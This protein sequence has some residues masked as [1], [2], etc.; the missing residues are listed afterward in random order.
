MKAIY[1]TLLFIGSIILLLSTFSFL[2]PWEA[3]TIETLHQVAKW[4]FY[5]FILEFV[6]GLIRAQEKWEYVKKEW[7]STLAIVASISVESLSGFLGAV[8]LM[9]VASLLKSLKGIKAF[10]SFKAIKSVKILKSVKLGKKARKSIRQE[11]EERE[12]EEAK[13][14]NL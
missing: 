14:I 12:A 2:L 10:K 8:K 7:I 13:Q 6:V 11:I 3:T 5:C 4:V 1:Y 9:K